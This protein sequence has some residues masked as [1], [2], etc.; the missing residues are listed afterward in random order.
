M[1]TGK[2]YNTV[3][4]ANIEKILRKRWMFSRNSKEL[5]LPHSSGEKTLEKSDKGE[6]IGFCKNRVLPW[7]VCLASFNKSPC[8]GRE[9]GLALFY[10]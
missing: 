4:P 2:K 5:E 9:L 6:I 1:Q 8:L 3:A 10:V 7:S